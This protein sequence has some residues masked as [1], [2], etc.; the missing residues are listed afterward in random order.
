MITSVNPNSKILGEATGKPK[1]AG[2]ETNEECSLS[3]NIKGEDRGL[4]VTMSL[5]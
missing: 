3:P 1:Q 4:F 5:R 2:L